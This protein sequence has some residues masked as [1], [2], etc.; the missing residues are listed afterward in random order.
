MVGLV[1]LL[2]VLALAL[3][4]VV[5]SIKIVGQAEVMVVERLGAS[6]GSP[7]PGSTS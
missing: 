6:T 5:A 4:L 3:S 7:P 1:V 2:V